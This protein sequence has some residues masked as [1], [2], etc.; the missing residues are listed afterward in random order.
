VESI[1]KKSILALCALTL[2]A[3]LSACGGGTS[4]HTIGGTVTGLQYGPLVLVTNGM[5]VSIKAQLDGS[6]NP[7]A[8]TY[9][10]PNQL[11]YG[12]AYHVMLKTGTDAS[13]NTISLQPPHQVCMPS[14]EPGNSTADTAGRLSVVKADFVC[15]LASHTIGGTINNLTGS[16]LKLINGS[17]GGEVAPAAGAASFTFSKEVTFNTTYGVVISSQPSGQTCTV[18]NGAGT[19]ADVAVTSIVVNCV[20][21]Q[22]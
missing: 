14:S 8:T 4:S 2:A 5:E 6:G 7:V 16:G 22:T 11:E 19:M 10:F 21:K 1:L 18:T 15:V 20:N 9:A 12:E 3:G 17:D 13:G